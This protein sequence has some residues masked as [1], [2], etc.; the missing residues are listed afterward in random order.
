MISPSI[1]PTYI[2]PLNPKPI[3][4]LK[5]KAARRPS[6]QHRPGSIPAKLTWN[7]RFRREGYM[8][9]LQGFTS[10]TRVHMYI[11]IYVNTHM[12]IYVYRGS[13]EGVIHTYESMYA[14]V[15]VHVCMYVW[16]D[17]WM[18]GWLYIYIYIYRPSPSYVLCGSFL[19]L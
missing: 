5:K 8:E 9:P 17:G 2:R 4:P 18:D 1:T 19:G 13:S 14:H 12:N 10:G 11:Y 7:L 15:C 3:E 6:D 16:M